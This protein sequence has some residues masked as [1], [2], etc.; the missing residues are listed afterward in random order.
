MEKLINREQIAGMNIHYLFY[1]LEYFL[2]AQAKAGFRTIELWPGTPHF[3]LSYLEYSDCKRVRKSIEE[4]AL[5]VKIITPENCTYQYQFAAQEKEQ[6]EKSAQYFK[7]ALDVGEELG[8]E[9]MAINSGW[10]YWNEER[11]EAWKRSREM[12]SALAEYAKTKNIRLAMESLR[13]QESNLATTIQD[14]KRMMNE[15]NHSNLKA[16][17]DITAMGVAGETI[18]QWFAA[19]GDDII[20]MHFIDGNPYGHLIWGD[21]TH[22]LKSLLEAVNRHGYKGYLGQEITEFDYFENPAAA[23]WRN[24]KAYEP[25]IR[26]N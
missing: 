26:D 8:V 5:Q 18:D 20:H 13:P 6:F 17:I 9:I 11:E 15:V 23:D 7:K 16:M 25:F 2:D 12:L 10:G 3:F 22:D 21:G 24:M 4:R 14:V 1:S 19:L